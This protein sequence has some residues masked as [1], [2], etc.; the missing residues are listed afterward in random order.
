MGI[1]LLDIFSAFMVM[2]A[3]IDILGSIPIILTIKNKGGHIKAGQ[4]SIVAFLLLLAFH[5]LGERI[6]SL[7]GVDISSFAIAGS[8]I[9]LFLALEMVLGIEF[10]KSDAPASASIVPIAFPLVA[11]AGSI[12]TLISLRAEYESI[13]III[14][15]MLNMVVVY[16]VLKMTRWFERILGDAGI[17]ILK[18]FFGIILLAI[19]VKLFMSNTGIVLKNG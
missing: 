8:F 13:N 18:K 6:L 2:F 9:I 7:F 14:A 12:T 16:L 19:A 3:V 4:A 5:F 17:L 1:N 15:L 11:G 10:F